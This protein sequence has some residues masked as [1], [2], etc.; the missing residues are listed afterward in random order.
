[1]CKGPRA[2][3]TPLPAR[4]RGSTVVGR[5]GEGRRECAEVRPEREVGEGEMGAR[6]RIKKSTSGHLAAGYR[7]EARRLVKVLGRH[8]GEMWWQGPGRGQMW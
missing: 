8:S 5:A 2:A 1:M 4:L 6:P 7:A 3:P